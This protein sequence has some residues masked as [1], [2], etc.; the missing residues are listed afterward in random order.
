MVVVRLRVAFR[1]G[2]ISGTQNGS[3]IVEL[4]AGVV[5][6]GCD[7]VYSLPRL[8]LQNKKLYVKSSIYIIF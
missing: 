2:A 8:H 3:V 6:T 5:E 1:R 4:D 7:W